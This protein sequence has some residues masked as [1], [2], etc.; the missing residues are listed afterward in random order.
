[1]KPLKFKSSDNDT[2]LIFKKRR[3]GQ[4]L[5]KGE[6]REIRA[7]RKKLRKQM[8]GDGI[9]SKS[10]FERV[11]AELGLY[12][13][14]TRWFP[15]WLFFRGKG[16]L[17][18]LGASAALLAALAGLSAISEMK[19]HFTINLTDD[20]FREGFVLSD[21]ITFENPTSRLY[22]DP[23]FDAPCISIVDIPEDVYTKDGSNNGREYFAYTFYTRNEGETIIDYSYEIRINSESKDLS[24]ATW[25]MLFEDDKM[26]F[27]A[28]ETQV[29][30]VA[31]PQMLPGAGETTR[32]YLERPMFEEAMYPDHQYELF[33]TTSGGIN[34][35]RLIPY[36]FESENIVVSGLVKGLKPME[37]R[38][39]TVVIW[40]EGD[41]P[42]CTN[43]LIG[44]HLGAEVQFQ[45]VESDSDGTKEE[46]S[47]G[48]QFLEELESIFEGLKFWED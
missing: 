3:G 45:L 23:V 30:G 19:G 18:L 7:G 31:G 48:Q 47:P 42:D 14:K 32:G 25:V 6:I 37:I 46:M 4:V 27:F 26:R 21:S 39:Y 2:P 43:E 9:R 22:S 5:T 17:M 44:G 29:D 10:E 24:K 36:S 15:F 20:L 41:D 33:H 28:E 35:Y 8:R 11:A 34:F 12:F 1:M 38:K 40:L 13:D 16:L